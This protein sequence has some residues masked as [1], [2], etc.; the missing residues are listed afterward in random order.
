LRARDTTKEFF[1]GKPTEE[2]IHYYSPDEWINSKTPATFILGANDD[3]VGNPASAACF[4]ETLKKSNVPAEL[5]I[6]EK[7]GHGLG[8]IDPDVF[9]ALM[10]QFVLWLRNR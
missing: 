2:R 5:H 4:Y 3:S 6:Y 1:G 7:G 8:R 10:N 9:D